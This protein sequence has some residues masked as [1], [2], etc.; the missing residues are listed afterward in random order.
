MRHSRILVVG[1]SG[2]IGSQVVSRLAAD[3]RR[4]IVP[5]RRRER[6]RHLLPLPT[7][8]VVEARVGEPGALAALVAGCDAVINLVGVLHGRPGRGDEWGPDFDRA[9]VALPAA[10]V[11]ACRAHGVRRL[12]HVS[13]LGVTDG[14]WYAL[15]SRYLR[16]KAAGEESVRRAADLDWTILRP[17]VVFGAGDAF[18]NLFARLH[19]TLPV[20]AVARADARFQ[21]VWVGDVA[22]AIA[23]ALDEPA[24]HRR[25]FALAG[26]EV[27]T[28][29]ELVG[30]AGE[31]SGR[32][33]PVIGLPAG[34]GRLV[35]RLMELAPGE[36]LM[37]RD[38]LDS[39]SID[40]VADGPIDPVLRVTPA[41]LAA[42]GP[43][44][45][46]RAAAERHDE[47]RSRARR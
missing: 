34:P 43:V 27:F 45:Y 11:E 20:L 15:P 9:H 46:G 36:P 13:A 4:A 23:N 12:V 26:P 19:R 31:W 6:A 41:S 10:L 42:M 18:L 24:T 7:V 47:R 25:A 1:G 14:G 16:S 22:Q 33:R 28:L 29:R 5:T 21:P 37:T 40:N 30:L 32:R 3:G 35:A 17:S 44:L 2:F 38:N 8:E 39:M